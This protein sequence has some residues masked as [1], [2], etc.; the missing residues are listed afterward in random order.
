VSRPGLPS[1]TARNAGR[2]SHAS[3]GA[4]PQKVRGNGERAMASKSEHRNS[5]SAQNIESKYIIPGFGKYP[6]WA[7]PGADL[8]MPFPAE[9][10]QALF[11]IPEIPITPFPK[12]FAISWQK[13]WISVSES[14]S[15][16]S[17]EKCSEFFEGDGLSTLRVL[18]NRGCDPNFVMSL[19]SRYLWNERVPEQE[20]KDPNA[21]SHLEDLKAVQSTRLLFRNHTWEKT[22]ETK[23]VDRALLGLETIIQSYVDDLDFRSGRHLQNDKQNRVIYAIHHHLKG[24]DVGPQWRLFLDLL[25]AA[26]AVWFRQSKNPVSDSSDRR[27]VPRLESF[28]SEH[29]K[30]AQLMPTWVR[31]WPVD[32]GQMAKLSLKPGPSE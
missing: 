21:R 16:H 8:P 7:K 6:P 11:F 29:P 27:I 15:E 23:L 24:N 22:P 17:K 20:H 13:R 10:M 26:G 2:F 19:L 1:A 5:G 9:F 4:L 25:V 18:A 28:Q 12:V 30:E 31:S 14:I 32:F 3:Q